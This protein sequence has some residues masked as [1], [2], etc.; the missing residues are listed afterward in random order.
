MHCFSLFVGH[1]V[2]AGLV[3]WRTGHPEVG[4]VEDEVWPHAYW[5]D[6]VGLEWPVGRLAQLAER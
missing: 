2:G 5:D 1:P 6:V 3:T 4:L